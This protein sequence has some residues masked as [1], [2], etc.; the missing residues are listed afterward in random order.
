MT[1]T[2][3]L[4]AAALLV[5]L[6]LSPVL[7]ASATAQ[8]GRTDSAGA[9]AAVQR[10]DAAL[11]AG[12]SVAAVSLLSPDVLI[13]ESGNIQSRLDYLRGHLGA[14]MKASKGAKVVRTLVNA[15][16]M[17]D[18]A[19]VVSRTVKPP[20]DAAGSTGSES[21]ELMVLSKGA[22]GWMIRAIHW[23]SRRQR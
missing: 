8:T 13:L 7:A 3:R 16:T 2:G 11:T 6:A 21:A 17:G 19:Y 22:S 23:S 10:F 12:D 20:T 4:R 1:R 9:V 15:T 14:D 5:A 18:A